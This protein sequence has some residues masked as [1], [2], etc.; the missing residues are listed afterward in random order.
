MLAPP[1][2]VNVVV[3]SGMPTLKAESVPLQ[4]IFM[5][6][7]NNAL[8]YAHKP[9]LCVLVEVRQSGNYYEFSVA[10]NGPGIAP[11]YHQKIWG[12]FQRLESRDKIEGTGISLSV[13][14]KIVESRGEPVWIESEVGLAPPSISLGPST[15]KLHLYPSL[16][17]DP[18]PLSLFDRRSL[19]PITL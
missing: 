15:P 18:R 5:N 9:D 17:T 4:Q 13:V 3:G 10:D 7:I 11:E 12:I 6:L 14:K 16:Y 2:E 8:K 1:P 19:P